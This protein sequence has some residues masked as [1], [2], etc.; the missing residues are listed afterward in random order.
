MSA[1]HLHMAQ[2]DEEG[3]ATLRAVEDDLDLCIVALASPSVFADLS[4][5][6][7]QRLQTLERELGG[8][9]LAYTHD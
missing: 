3:L 2:L 7:L 1:P 6:Q 5:A 9:L 4:E 8:T